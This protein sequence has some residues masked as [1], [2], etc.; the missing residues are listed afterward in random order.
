MEVLFSII[1]STAFRKFVIAPLTVVGFYQIF[2]GVLTILENDIYEHKLRGWM[3]KIY[4]A[5]TILGCI[6]L[7]AEL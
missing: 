1:E 5:I 7:V 3:A 6:V 4:I 2:R